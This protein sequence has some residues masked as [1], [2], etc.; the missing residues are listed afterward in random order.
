MN[1]SESSRLSCYNSNHAPIISYWLAVLS[2]LVY[3]ILVITAGDISMEMSESGKCLNPEKLNI[4]PFTFSSASRLEQQEKR[5]KETKKWSSPHPLNILCRSPLK[6]WSTCCLRWSTWCLNSLRPGWWTWQTRSTSW[7]LTRTLALCWRSHL[8]T[9]QP[10]APSPHTVLRFIH[11]YIKG[12]IYERGN[13]GYEAAVQN[14]LSKHT[15]EIY[16]N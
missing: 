5:W 12:L 13:R 11:I 9:Q 16:K 2:S 3:G 7:N 1:G 6:K 10:S 8:L 15:W 4:R 14:G